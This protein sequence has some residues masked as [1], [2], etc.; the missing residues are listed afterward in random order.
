M[1]HKLADETWAAILEHILEVPDDDFISCETTSGPFSRRDYSNADVLLVCKRWLRIAT[2]LVFRTCIIRS[3]A[4]AQVLAK[5]LKKNPE[6][7][8]LVKQ[9]RLEG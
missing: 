7:G 6:F 4:Q 8:V 5:A 1:A 9:L 2:P 3:T